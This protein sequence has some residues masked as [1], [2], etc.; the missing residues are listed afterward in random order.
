MLVWRL[1][2]PV[3]G[4]ASGPYGGGLGPC[5]WVINATVDKAYGR[6]DPDHH[7]TELAA[8]LGLAGTGVGLIT[9]VDVGDATSARDG[10]VSVTATVGLGHPTWAAA[11]DGDLRTG[12]GTIN[13]V[14]FLPVA[15][16][17]A[18]MVNAVITATEAK[19][20]ALWE[21]GAEATGT[22]SDALFIGCGAGRIGPAVAA[23]PDTAEAFAGPRSLWGARLARAVHAAVGQGTARWMDRYGR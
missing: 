1:P 4:I 16:S 20:Q 5:Q 13:I 11:P 3:R 18:A 14:A 9:A 21:Y 6:D 2:R 7:I 19:A 23:E 8:G 15:L 10:G 17:D 12:P 22:A